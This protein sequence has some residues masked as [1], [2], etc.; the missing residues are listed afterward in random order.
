[1]QLRENLRKRKAQELLRICV[2]KWCAIK[3]W[4]L[5]TRIEARS[6]QPA[7]SE[8]GLSPQFGDEGASLPIWALRVIGRG[9][10]YIAAIV[11]RASRLEGRGQHGTG[12][13]YLEW[14][15]V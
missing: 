3:G 9:F 8:L 15:N 14:D 5:A 1:M 2:V 11:E 10:S 6:L 4:D 12:Y 13:P 7:P